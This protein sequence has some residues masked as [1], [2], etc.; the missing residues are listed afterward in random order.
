MSYYFN[1]LCILSGNKLKTVI[2]CCSDNDVS[3]TEEGILRE[4]E[5][6]ELRSLQLSDL[7]VT[8]NELQE[9]K[10]PEDDS[11]ATIDHASNEEQ[12]EEVQPIDQNISALSKALKQ[13]QPKSLR[14]RQLNHLLQ[15]WC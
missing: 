12:E 7:L 14:Y 2:I 4:T 8:K 3:E 6:E 13:C 1:I 15:V 11:D 5:K 10:T 9:L